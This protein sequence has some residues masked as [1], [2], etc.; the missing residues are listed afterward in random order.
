MEKNSLLY[1]PT[2]EDKDVPGSFYD[3][4]LPKGALS[5]SSFSLYKT[6]PK[7]YEYRYVLEV[8]SPGNYNMLRGTVIHAGA[9]YAIKKK[10]KEGKY[11]LLEDVLDTTASLYE[12]KVVE[13][14]DTDGST[15]KG[16]HKDNTLEGVSVYY[17]SVLPQ[18]NP[19]SAERKFI[20]KIDGI[21]VRG[22]IDL[23]D[24]VKITDVL[25]REDVPQA[26]ELVS[27]LKVVGRKW[28]QQKI[29]MHSQFTFYTLVRGETECRIDFIVAGKNGFKYHPERTSRSLREQDILRE[30]LECVV[31]GIKM[32]I[33]PRCDPTSWICTPKYCAYWAECRG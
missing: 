12:D 11:P 30:D 13:V 19:V 23:I 3:K 4:E 32:G 27:D 7:N 8:P 21:P 6:C 28:T 22:I 9:E 31:R 25:S 33:F 29:D 10:L 18:I 24:K 5:P 17:K 26:Q 2:F 15:N 16:L 14:V 20:A 1:V